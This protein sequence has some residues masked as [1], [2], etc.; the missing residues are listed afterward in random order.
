MANTVSGG[1]QS[2]LPQRCYPMPVA[3]AGM[4]VPDAYSQTMPSASQTGASELP[5]SSPGFVSVVDLI[6]LSEAYA[7][8]ER[9]L[10]LNSPMIEDSSPSLVHTERIPTTRQPDPRHLTRCPHACPPK[11]IPCDS[12]RLLSSKSAW[13]DVHDFAEKGCMIAHFLVRC[14]FI[15]S[16]SSFHS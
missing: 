5:T 10:L 12:Q 14:I 2:S 3:R 9:K 15:L 4:V 16:H 13:V 8:I 11:P 1:S 6:R 7:E